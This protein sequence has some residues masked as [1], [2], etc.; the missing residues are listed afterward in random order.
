LSYRFRCSRGFHTSLNESL[1][2]L[3]APTD[4]MDDGVNVK[5]KHIVNQTCR[6]LSDCLA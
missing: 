5:K 4:E 3:E 6:R 1:A 2:S